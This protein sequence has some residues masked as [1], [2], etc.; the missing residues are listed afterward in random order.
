MINANDLQK[1]RTN[2]TFNHINSSDDPLVMRILVLQTGQKCSKVA[3]LKFFPLM[4]AEK[5]ILSFSDVVVCSV[6]LS[7]ANHTSRHTEVMMPG[8]SP[9]NSFLSSWHSLHH[10]PSTETLFSCQS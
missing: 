9:L 1:G 4:T 6:L 5:K 10:L 8:S 2:L 7:K 3:Q